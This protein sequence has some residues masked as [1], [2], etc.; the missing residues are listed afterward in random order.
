MEKVITKII[1]KEKRTHK[2][3]CDSCGKY[4]GSSEEYDD[5]YYNEICEFSI[6]IHDRELGTYAIHK[7]FCNECKEKF[8]IKFRQI[9]IENGFEG[10]DL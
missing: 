2:F 10:D 6:D 3:Y 1:E 9:L 4:L 8:L 7:N 5:G